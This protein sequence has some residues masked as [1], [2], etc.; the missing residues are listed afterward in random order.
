MYVEQ[1]NAWLRICGKIRITENQNIWIEIPLQQRQANEITTSQQ[2]VVKWTKSGYS[3]EYG[4]SCIK[5][6]L[7]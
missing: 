4:H 5:S 1:W 2:N 7:M 6:L 3:S